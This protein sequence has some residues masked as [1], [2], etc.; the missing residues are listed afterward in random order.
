[1]AWIQGW[2]DKAYLWLE[3]LAG[4]SVVRRKFR[5]T[6]LGAQLT[7]YSVAG[8]QIRVYCQ[9]KLYVREFLW[10]QLPARRYCTFRVFGKVTSDAPDAL[11]RACDYLDVNLPRL[12]PGFV[13]TQLQKE[14]A[15]SAYLDILIGLIEDE[16]RTWSPSMV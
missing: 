2:I 1:M 16:D 7:G 13:S 14:A 4:A 6:D 10:W 5:P 3:Q 8:Y 11:R 9:E 12:R 15:V